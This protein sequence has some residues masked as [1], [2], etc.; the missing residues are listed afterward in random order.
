M[1]WG[2]GDVIRQPGDVI[3]RAL[4][5]DSWGSPGWSGCD[6]IS[7]I[8]AVRGE[9]KSV[10]SRAVPVIARPEYT[11]YILARMRTYP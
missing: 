1:V 7:T 10:S 6:A 8:I 2:P 5:C 9:K 11:L 4:G 3:P